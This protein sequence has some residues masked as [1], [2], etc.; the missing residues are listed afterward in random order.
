MRGSDVDGD[1]TGLE[2]TWLENEL[3]QLEG[4]EQRSRDQG[5]VLSPELVEP[6]ADALDELER[7]VADRRDAGDEHGPSVEAVQPDDDPVQERPAWVELESP[8]QVIGD[9]PEV[10]SEM[11]DQ[12]RAR[13]EQEQGARDSLEGDQPE[14]AAAT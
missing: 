5:Q 8:S 13:R 10:A 11:A 2:Q 7:A 4:D 12:V 1:P 6:K 9:P 3:V 14:D